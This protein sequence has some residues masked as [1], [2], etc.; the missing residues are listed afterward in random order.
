MVLVLLELYTPKGDTF[1]WRVQDL[2]LGGCVQPFKWIVG[3][4]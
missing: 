1:Q 4:E 2:T 3:V